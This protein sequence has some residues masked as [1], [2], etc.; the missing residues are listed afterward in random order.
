MSRGAAQEARRLANAAMK[1]RRAT[2]SIF[3]FQNLSTIK[4]EEFLC[5][6]GG[7][8]SDFFQRNSASTGDFFR[9]N[10]RVSRFA[11]F[12][13]KRDRSEVRA[14]GFD[15]K[16]VEWNFGGDIADL[17]SVLEC[18]NTSERNEMA[19]TQNFVCLFECSAETMKHATD[20]T[21]VFAQNL[22]GV[23]PGIALMNDHVEFQFD[24][25]IEKLLE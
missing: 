22:E 2:M 19:E 12:S 21:T 5:S 9:D 16:T 6:C 25:E 15:H 23:V 8:A 24:R 11:A 18:H 14:I 7:C 13:S 17:F 3:S 4:S 20:L 10:A 1:I